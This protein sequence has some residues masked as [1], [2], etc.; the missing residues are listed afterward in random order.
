MFCPNPSSPQ[1]RP[2]RVELRV[3]LL[4]GV[5]A[6]ELLAHPRFHR[7]LQ[8]CDFRRNEL[9]VGIREFC[10]KRGYVADEFFRERTYLLT[11]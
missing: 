5:I 3:R 1:V 10:P 11:R 4:D 7:C 2:H 6:G 8:F 9:R